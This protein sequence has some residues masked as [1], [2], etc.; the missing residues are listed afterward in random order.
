MIKYYI[1]LLITVTGIVLLSPPQVISQSR[2]QIHPPVYLQFVSHNEDQAIWLTQSYYLSKRTLLV[3][4][5]NIV[6]AKN[7]KWDFQS[8]WAFLLAVARF[9]TGSVVSNTN[10]KNLIKWMTENKG[11][12]CDP[13]SHENGGYNYADVAYLHQALGI[14]PTKIVGGF[15]YDTVVNGNNWENLEAGIYG[16]VYTSYFWKPDALWGSGTG[17]HLN[18]PY[19][20]G[21]W[22]PK[23][24]QNYYLHD[25]TKHLMLIGHGCA[26]HIYDTSNVRTNVNILN[27]IVNGLNTG[28]L[29][30]TGFY[31]AYVY[32]NVGD[33]TTTRVTK[34]SQ[35]IDSVASLVIAGRVLWKS[36]PEVYDI[37][38]TSYG[39]KPYWIQCENLP[40]EV[41]QINYTVPEKFKLFQNYPNPFNPTTKIKFEIA[42]ASDVMLT[43]YDVLGKEV[44]VVL[45]EK[46]GVGIYETEWNAENFAAGVYYSRMTAGGLTLT[47]KMM[48][49]K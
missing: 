34:I 39:K 44:A 13:H 36:L 28:V 38:N 41:H 15:L 11:I 12:T 35:F 2:S 5:A 8:D 49:V 37:W 18:D 26:N 6:Q 30:D 3:D 33:L 9:D 17:N 43:I 47:T 27:Q 46:L 19:P 48:L 1:S 7:A 16:R 22:K 14:I 25:S 42:E 21:A 23:S 45:N 31:P 20:L 4:I 32:F 24:M 40:T 10:G 29:P